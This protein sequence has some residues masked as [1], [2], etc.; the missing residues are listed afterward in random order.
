MTLTGLH[1]L[2]ANYQTK[3]RAFLKQTEGLALT[4][5]FDSPNTAY[6]H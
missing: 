2:G 1:A 4:P 6:G 3:L 5:Y